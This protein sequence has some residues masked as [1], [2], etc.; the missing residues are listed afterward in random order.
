MAPFNRP[1]KMEIKTYNEATP[2]KGFLGMGGKEKK[3]E[4]TS[5][6][7]WPRLFQDLSAVRMGQ[8]AEDVAQAVR[9]EG[10]ILLGLSSPKRYLWADDEAWLEGDI[11][12]MADPDDRCGTH[13]YVSLLQGPLIRYLVEHDPDELQLP[14]PTATQISEEEVA[15]LQAVPW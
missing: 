7:V 14:D 3:P 9:T 6:F 13:N 11:W 2:K 12:H 15:R 4:S 1:P 5:T 10:D 8:E